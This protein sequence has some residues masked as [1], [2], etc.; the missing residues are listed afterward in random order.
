MRNSIKELATIIL[1]N[2][3]KFSDDLLEIDFART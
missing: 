3:N 1:N 2:K